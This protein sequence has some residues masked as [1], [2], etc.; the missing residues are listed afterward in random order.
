MFPIPVG[1]PVADD[2]RHDTVRE[3][4]DDALLVGHGWLPA[5]GGTRPVAPW[6]GSSSDGP[7]RQGGCGVAAR[8]CDRCGDGLRQVNAFE[9]EQVPLETDYFAEFVSLAR[10]LNESRGQSIAHWLLA[11]HAIFADPDTISVG[12]SANEAGR[13]S[14]VDPMGML[15]PFMG[16]ARRHTRG[17]AV[18]S[19]P[20]EEESK[21]GRTARSAWRALPGSA[22][23]HWRATIGQ[24]TSATGRR[25][26]LLP[27]PRASP[28]T[29]GY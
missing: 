10:S 15:L 24:A 14:D 21:A 23:R 12:D 8:A 13:G 1:A 7:G 29:A 16:S 9:A 11:L 20:A 3:D 27:H 17:G 5:G 22:A 28:A 2:L 26:V 18:I 25:R 4:G 6:G 19:S